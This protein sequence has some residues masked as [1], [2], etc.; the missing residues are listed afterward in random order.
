M[1]QKFLLMV[2]RQD[3]WVIREIL[4]SRKGSSFQNPGYKELWTIGTKGSKDSVQFGDWYSLLH[5]LTDKA[6]YA[7]P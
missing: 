2:L 6:A 3:F 4:V 1:T 7:S 5:Q